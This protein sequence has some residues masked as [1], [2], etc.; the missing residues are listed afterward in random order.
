MRPYA[1][2]HSN[3]RPH[4]AVPWWL[5]LHVRFRQM[6]ALDFVTRW[7]AAH[8]PTSKTP[9]QA[10]LVLVPLL[11]V[12]GCVS[13]SQASLPATQQA[14]PTCTQPTMLQ[15]APW[16]D[17]Q[18]NWPPNWPPAAGAAPMRQLQPTGYVQ[19]CCLPRSVKR[20]TRRQ[21]AAEAGPLMHTQVNTGTHTLAR[22]Y[23]QHMSLITHA[24]AGKLDKHMHTKQ[25]M[26]HPAESSRQL[27]LATSLDCAPGQG[28]FCST[29]TRTREAE[30]LAKQDGCQAAVTY[31]QAALESY[32]PGWP[33]Q[34]QTCPDQRHQPKH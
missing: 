29:T 10:T 33:H 28:S 6:C 5:S 15:Q 16:K 12:T 30:Q 13:D 17:T 34:Q 31:S 8:A 26:C 2:L 23:T 7:V 21:V 27:G 4:V 9:T 1:Q 22:P 24:R 14:D 20:K 3:N 11:P 32:Y 19:V 18:K 25:R